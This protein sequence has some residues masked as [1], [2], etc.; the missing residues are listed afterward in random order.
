[1]RDR[2][3]FVESPAPNTTIR[4]NKEKWRMIYQGFDEKGQ[5][6]AVYKHL[7]HLPTAYVVMSNKHN[8]FEV[9]YLD[10][11]LA[12]ARKLLGQIQ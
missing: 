11:A 7:P 4:I 8:P 1:M 10:L 2:L 5:E 12:Y 9:V 6:V 3:R